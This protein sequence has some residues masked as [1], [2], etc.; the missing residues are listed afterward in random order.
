MIL[1]H[2]RP[3]PCQLTE[4]GVCPPL[5][6]WILIIIIIILFFI[7]QYIPGVSSHYWRLRLVQKLGA[8]STH[9]CGGF[10]PRLDS[11]SLQM[12]LNHVTTD[13]GWYDNFEDGWEAE[14]PEALRAVS[15]LEYTVDRNLWIAKVDIRVAHV[16]GKTLHD[17]SIY[18]NILD[19]LIFDFK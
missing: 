1:H 16:R 8:Q 6:V 13:E 9:R 10:L 14:H 2:R 11:I 4:T 7:R 5:F 17:L 18:S 12:I 15:L 3:G 19:C